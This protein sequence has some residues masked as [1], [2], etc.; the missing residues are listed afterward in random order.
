M[1][2]LIVSLRWRKAR[3]LGS[4]RLCSQFSKVRFEICNL[5]AASDC[6]RRRA[7]RQARNWSA[8]ESDS[9]FTGL[10]PSANPSPRMSFW[11]LYAI[12]VCDDKRRL[13]ILLHGIPWP[14]NTKFRSSYRVRC[15]LA[16][17]NGVGA[18]NDPDIVHALKRVL[19]LWGEVGLP[20]RRAS[21]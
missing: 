18:L 6:E 9:L 14:M 7:F 10:R 15:E 11:M 3:P 13:Q 19:A 21:P 17:A 2:Y 4:R 8:S 12:G 16:Y 1:D 20:T 5:S